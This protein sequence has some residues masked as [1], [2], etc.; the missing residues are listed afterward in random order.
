MPL[1]ITQTKIHCKST[2]SDSSK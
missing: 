1:Y 2:E